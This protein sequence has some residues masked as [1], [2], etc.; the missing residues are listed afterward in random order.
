MTTKYKI[1][2]VRHGESEWN[3]LNLFCGW[4]DAPLSQ[5]GIAE[6]HDAGK[7]LKEKGYTFDVAYTSVLKRAVK[8]LNIIQE[9][10]D[11]DWIPVHRHY[12]LN[13]RM[14]GGLTGLN[15]AETAKLHG[16][17]K[18]KIWRRSYAIPPPDVDLDSSEYPGNDRRYKM[19]DKS[20]I[21][22]AECLKDTVERVLPYWFD[23]IVPSI[24]SGQRVIVSAHGNSLRGLVKYLDKIPDDE[25]V[26]LNIPTGL[27]LVYELDED[28]K[29]VK[30][31]YLASEEEV[32][33]RVAKVVAQGKSK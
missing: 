20:L 19:V 32:A 10:L 15:K 31:Y 28:L 3:K 12:R 9:E 16:E 4:H 7:L 24:L 1:V 14:Y 33:A 6:A 21:P 22:R 29:P 23:A 11:L 8:T 2:L 26:G 17:D 13:E 27:P 5:T 30:H 25:I 18:V